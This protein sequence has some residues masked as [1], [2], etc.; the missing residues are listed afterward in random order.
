MSKHPLVGNNTCKYQKDFPFYLVGEQACVL[1]TR[2]YRL[3]ELTA[4]RP[5]TT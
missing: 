5:S 4:N 2:I 1:H 3:N